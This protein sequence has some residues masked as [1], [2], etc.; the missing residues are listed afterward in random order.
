MTYQ[1]RRKG[2]YGNRKSERDGIKF[3]SGKEAKRYRDL[4]LLAA[5]GEIRDLQLQV[6]F[7]LT[8]NGQKICKYVADFTY[9]DAKGERVVEDAK[10]FKTPIYRLKKKLVKACHGV[11]IKEV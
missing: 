11:E 4:K 1:I 8:V 9:R 5:A 7:E 6:P 3:D 10:G 2:K